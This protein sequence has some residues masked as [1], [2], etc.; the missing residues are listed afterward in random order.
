MTTNGISSSNTTPYQSGMRSE[1][2]QRGQDFKVLDSALQAGDLS[3][4]QKAFASLQQDMQNIQGSR[5]QQGQNQ[6]QN[7]PFANDMKAL[8]DAL[9][10][11][12][13]SAAQKAFA[14]LKQDMQAARQA[15][16]GQHHHARGN[17]GDAD[18]SSATSS[19]GSGNSGLSVKA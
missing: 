2:K 12:D 14:T 10:S 6:Q 16:G 4:A 18:D 5:S 7:S 8:S 11:G 13:M 1:F 9:G 19:S 15:H 3:G 17:D